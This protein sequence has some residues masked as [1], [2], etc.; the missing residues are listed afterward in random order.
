MKAHSKYCIALM[1][2][3]SQIKMLFDKSFTISHIAYDWNDS[4]VI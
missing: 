3:F 1:T 4:Y 2:G